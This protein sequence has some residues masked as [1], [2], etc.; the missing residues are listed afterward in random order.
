[1]VRKEREPANL[2]LAV[3]GARG[4]HTA[5]PSSSRPTVLSE[6]S[7]PHK[8]QRTSVPAGGEGSEA[9]LGKSVVDLED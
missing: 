1:M 6:D 4:G 2:R 7:Q 5:S 3:G 8:K 9:N